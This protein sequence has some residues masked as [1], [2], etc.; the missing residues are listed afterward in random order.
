M[1]H[2]NVC[3]FL[4]NEEHNSVN[5]KLLAMLLFLPLSNIQRKMCSV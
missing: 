5:I 1:I 2:A 4:E 3:F